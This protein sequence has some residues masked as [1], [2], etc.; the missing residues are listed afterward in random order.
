MAKRKSKDPV[1]ERPLPPGVT[2]VALDDCY[3]C[4]TT[5]YMLG[6][7]T[8]NDVYYGGPTEEGRAAAKAAAE[9]ER[10]HLQARFPDLTVL[11]HTLDD[12]IHEQVSD[13]KWAGEFEGG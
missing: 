6:Y 1:D 11:V 5:G 2:K 8:P 4:T 10:N 3:V 12:Q 13:A 7:S 9:A